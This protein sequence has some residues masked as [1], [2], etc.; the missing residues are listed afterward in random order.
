MQL[1]YQWK[2]Q[3]LFVPP[4]LTRPANILN[5]LR[6]VAQNFIVTKRLERISEIHVLSH[7]KTV[8]SLINL[9][10]H[11]H[12]GGD[13]F[14]FTIYPS[15]FHP[16]LSEFDPLD[17][18]AKAKTNAISTPCNCVKWWWYLQ[19]IQRMCTTGCHSRSKAS[20]VP[21]VFFSRHFNSSR[22]FNSL[23]YL[24][25]HFLVEELNELPLIT[26]D[27]TCLSHRL[28]IESLERVLGLV[29][30]NV[31]WL[32]SIRENSWRHQFRLYVHWLDKT[33]RKGH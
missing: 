22:G 6:C 12:D 30:S 8:T 23:F 27:R 1:G 31:A 13:V 11:T 16:N 14:T 21:S 15:L 19:E 3:Y 29:L 26:S 9:K 28:A 5:D 17:K 7:W 4:V 18:L 2:E 25:W 20:K 32:L 10:K 33:C 24:N